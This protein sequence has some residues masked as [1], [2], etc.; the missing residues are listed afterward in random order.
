MKNL[1]SLTTNSIMEQ[2]HSIP[3]RKKNGK[4]STID[5]LWNN[6][7]NSSPLHITDFDEKRLK[8][9]NSVEQIADICIEICSILFHNPYTIAVSNTGYENEPIDSPSI[10]DPWGQTFGY[11]DTDVNYDNE[12]FSEIKK[13]L[14]YSFIYNQSCNKDLASFS[15]NTIS[16]SIFGVDKS[17]TLSNKL[18]AI[19]KDNRKFRKYSLDIYPKYPSISR[20]NYSLPFTFIPQS[21]MISS[22]PY[23]PERY[24]DY[25]LNY[26]TGN[27][28]SISSYFDVIILWGLIHSEKIS[29]NPYL[30][31]YN[32][33]KK[34][35][36]TYEIDAFISN[37][38]P[39]KIFSLSS[40]SE[41]APK[42]I[43]IIL[44]TIIGWDKTN[45][46]NTGKKIL[47]ANVNFLCALTTYL[48]ERVTNI[49]LIRKI[50]T[51]HAK[52]PQLAELDFVFHLSAYPLISYRLKIIEYLQC[53]WE[54]SQAD[55]EKYTNLVHLTEN[56]LGDVEEIDNKISPDNLMIKNLKQL[57][58]KF[59][60][61][62]HH[63]VFLAFP[64]LDVL[65]NLSLLRYNYYSKILPVEKFKEILGENYKK[66]SA[67]VLFNLSNKN[68]YS[69]S[70]SVSLFTLGN[71]SNVNYCK[72]ID[73][74]F[75]QF[76]SYAI[77]GDKL[78]EDN[79]CY[80]DKEYLNRMR[81]FAS[82]IASHYLNLHLGISYSTDNVST[83][84]PKPFSFR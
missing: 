65:F 80:L 54:K 47:E 59:C 41:S 40:F 51:L 69:K 24:M 75:D 84:I 52:Y 56:P 70:P 25:L 48:I 18:A 7:K 38:D 12:F 11:S 33:D 28:T 15:L 4:N 16:K 9:A 62:I 77:Q 31:K 19:N 35:E 53:L 43:S 13:F 6:F 1:F 71:T 17:Y 81:Y 60:T 57:S 83:K 66:L 68:R 8:E 82:C 3:F 20:H 46:T 29:R 58:H 32:H 42:L 73:N 67:S 61:L 79:M 5:N 37:F 22:D 64:Q 26:S 14:I 50:A 10:F 21:P 44:D 72:I 34:M 39:K 2:I 76:G 23:C 36:E 63:H 30:C 49:D 45:L 55:I 74:V 27:K 78:Q